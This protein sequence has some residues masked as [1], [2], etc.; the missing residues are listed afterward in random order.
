MAAWLRYNRG[1]PGTQN[2]I[3]SADDLVG[4]NLEPFGERDAEKRCTAISMIWETY[5]LHEENWIPLIRSL[6][7]FTAVTNAVGDRRA[8]TV[9]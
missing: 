1:L 8:P 3:Q 4:K 2:A 9:H 6:D 5:I 7:T